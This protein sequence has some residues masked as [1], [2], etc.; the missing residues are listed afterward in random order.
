VTAE[1]VIRAVIRVENANTTH[2]HAVIES[3]NV[4]PP[5]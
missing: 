1:S 2:P 3:Y 4:L 5:Y